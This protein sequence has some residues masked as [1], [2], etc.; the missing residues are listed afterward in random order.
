MYAL[1]VFSKLLPG[2]FTQPKTSGKDE[3]FILYL[4][5][6]IFV[7]VALYIINKSGQ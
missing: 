5:I 2:A 1:L 4:F 3:H 7:A 6:K